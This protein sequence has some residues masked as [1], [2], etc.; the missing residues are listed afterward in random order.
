M[1]A[2]IQRLPHLQFLWSYSKVHDANLALHAN[3]SSQPFH[4]MNRTN[5]RLAF[6]KIKKI[7]T[8]RLKVWTFKISTCLFT[9]S[10][11]W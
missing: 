10:P 5:V 7:L 3:L 6:D 4:L 11:N 2:V 9:R 8:T 1:D